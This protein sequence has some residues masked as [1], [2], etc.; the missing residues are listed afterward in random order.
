MKLI[1]TNRRNFLK[2]TA[3]AT[4]GT[5]MVPTILSSCSKG[6]NSRIQVAHIG[7]GARGTCNHKRLFSACP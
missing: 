6:A 1:K 5:I 3:F 2:T 7:V 4:A